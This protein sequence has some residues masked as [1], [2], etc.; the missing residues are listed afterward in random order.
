MRVAAGRAAS[1]LSC[2]PSACLSA[3][4]PP[5]QSTHRSPDRSVHRQVRRLSH[6]IPHVMPPRLALCLVPLPCPGASCLA[7]GAGDESGGP[8]A[9]IF[10]IRKALH[11]AP[12]FGLIIVGDEIL[13]GQT[14]RRPLQQGARDA[15]TGGPVAGLGALRR[16]RPRGAGPPLPSGRWQRRHRVQLRGIGATPDDHTRQ[17]VAMALGEPLVLHPRPSRSSCPA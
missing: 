17:A 7:G 8:Q 2:R 5:H 16:R 9:R 15:A 12:S 1:C 3:C 13:S 10:P 6:V 14:A 11:A 4:R